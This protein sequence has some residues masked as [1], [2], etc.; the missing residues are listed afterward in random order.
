MSCRN[1]YRYD[2]SFLDSFARR[3]V[4]ACD[5]PC[6]TVA[7]RFLNGIFYFEAVEQ[8]GRGVKAHSEN[9]GRDRD[10]VGTA[11]VLSVDAERQSVV[12]VNILSRG[13]RRPNDLSERSVGDIDILDLVVYSERV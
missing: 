5:K 11:A 6:G 8:G 9:I 13:R 10:F 4:G 1:E 2:G 7:R 3:R 12:S